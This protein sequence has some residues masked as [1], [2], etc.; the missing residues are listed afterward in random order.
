MGTD[1][2]VCTQRRVE[3]DWGGSY[4]SISARGRGCHWP[5]N[6]TLRAQ[7]ANRP[8]PKHPTQLSPSLPLGPPGTLLA[9]KRQAGTVLQGAAR[10]HGQLV[11]GPWAQALSLGAE[12]PGS[13]GLTHSWTPPRVFLSPARTWASTDKG[14]FRRLASDPGRRAVS[15]SDPFDWRGVCLAPGDH[16]DLSSGTVGP[17]GSAWP[18]G[19]VGL[20][21]ETT[22]PVR[23]AAMCSLGLE[24]TG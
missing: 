19:P 11:W 14:P 23:G 7:G 21:Q 24:V 13:L 17:E 6:P 10:G 20:P 3:P 22:T 8:S 5:A 15:Q 1:H 12:C 4:G 9:R 16:T 18:R 2:L